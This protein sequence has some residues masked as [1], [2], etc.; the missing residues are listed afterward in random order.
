MKENTASDVDNDS[1]IA[2]N[3]DLVTNNT[4]TPQMVDSNST[5]VENG[6][7]TATTDTNLNNTTDTNITNGNSD[8][9]VNTP[10]E[11]DIVNNTGLNNGLNPDFGMLNEL[12]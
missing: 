6:N 4:T 5:I 3:N 11:N 12:F 1:N 2:R 7:A 10:N 9:I 8:N